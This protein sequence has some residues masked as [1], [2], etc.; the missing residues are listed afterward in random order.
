MLTGP[1]PTGADVI[2]LGWVL[3]DWGDEN[4]RKILSNCYDALPSGGALLI[5]ESVLNDDLSG[6]S[7][8]VLM[9]LHMLV[10]CEPGARERS[11]SKYRSLLQET[12]YQF[13]SLVRL[14]APRDLLVARKP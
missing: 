2:A 1:Y 4:C 6:T 13:E 12:G 14:A 3:H 7:F 5:T 11:E 8:G 10:V 9:S